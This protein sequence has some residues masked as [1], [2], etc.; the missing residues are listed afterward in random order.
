MVC[1]WAKWDQTPFIPVG[2]RRDAAPARGGKQNA[3]T[4]LVVGCR[5]SVC[6]LSC[7]RQCKVEH[8]RSAIGMARAFDERALLELCAI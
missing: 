6:S 7:Q 1:F 4:V 2:A 5:C 3:E 8:L